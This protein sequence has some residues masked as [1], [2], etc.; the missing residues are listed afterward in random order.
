MRGIE[1]MVDGGGGGGRR[2]RNE[3]Q[4]GR[5]SVAGQGHG[6]SPSSRC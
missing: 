3:Q 6:V 5:A 4:E 2:W 1:I